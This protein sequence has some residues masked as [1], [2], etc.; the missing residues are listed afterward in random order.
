MASAGNMARVSNKMESAATAR[1]ASAGGTCEHRILELRR[2]VNRR[3]EMLQKQIE[4]ELGGETD[5]Q[6]A[7]D[8]APSAAAYALV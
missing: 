7:Y 3:R 1:S 5:D 2:R 8:L 4:H 6:G